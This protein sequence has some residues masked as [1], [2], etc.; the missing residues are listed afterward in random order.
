MSSFYHYFYDWGDISQWIAT[1]GL[2]LFLT[3]YT[4]FAKWWKHPVGWVVNVFVISLVL[5]LI[6]SLMALA[7][8]AGFIHFADSNW[9]KVLETCNLTFLVAAA[10]TGNIVWAYLHSKK[11][12][13]GEKHTKE[14]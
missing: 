4:I 3:L 6:P 7:D 8:P 1:A 11:A 5:I 2:V 13:P 12:L 14:G 10:L 9:Y